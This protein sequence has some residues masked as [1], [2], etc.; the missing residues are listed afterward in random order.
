MWARK[1]LNVTPPL[2]QPRGSAHHMVGLCSLVPVNH[3]SPLLRPL[4]VAA[5][6]HHVRQ[7]VPYVLPWP[8]LVDEHLADGA[9][10]ARLQVPQDARLADCNTEYSK[11]I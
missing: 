2:A 4:E 10:V 6:T 7:L 8:F 3:N 1:P 5:A 11:T 9:K